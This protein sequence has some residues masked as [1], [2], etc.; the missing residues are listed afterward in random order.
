M[1]TVDGSL[2]PD[3]VFEEIKAAVVGAGRS[4]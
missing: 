4:K 3:Q 2:P 1:V